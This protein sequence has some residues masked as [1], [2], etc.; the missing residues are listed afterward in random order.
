MPCLHRILDYGT[1][2]EWSSSAP[3]CR[4]NRKS[5]V[6]DEAGYYDSISSTDT[7]TCAKMIFAIIDAG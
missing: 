5:R 7:I 1:T 2:M 3:R 4:L 6:E